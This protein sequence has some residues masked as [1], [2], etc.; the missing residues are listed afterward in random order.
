M[1]VIV[2]G[3]ENWKHLLKDAKF[4][5]KVWTDYKNLE[6]FIKV[7]KL[8]RKQACWALYLLRFNFTLKYVLGT[9]MRKI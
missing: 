4:K 1:L 9:K 3:L 8:N 5:F 7:Y 6:Y 2:R